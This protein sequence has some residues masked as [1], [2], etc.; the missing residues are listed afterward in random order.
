MA[1]LRASEERSVGGS[2]RRS[3]A[4]AGRKALEESP[5]PQ[6]SRASK[7]IWR[8]FSQMMSY[9]HLNSFQSLF[10]VISNVFCQFHAQFKSFERAV[11]L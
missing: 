5:G 10:E 9:N 7:L 1:S 3:L 2:P 6:A 11:A 4:S 8:V